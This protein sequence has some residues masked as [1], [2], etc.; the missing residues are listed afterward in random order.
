M[1]R[2][3][4]VIPVAFRR[5]ATGEA[6]WLL[7]PAGNVHGALRAQVVTA[8]VSGA[9]DGGPLSLLV[10]RSASATGNHA[11]NS[12]DFGSYEQP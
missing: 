5:R 8:N 7:D 4:V 9:A 3:E 6:G 11:P 1:R 10:L 2:M 12:L